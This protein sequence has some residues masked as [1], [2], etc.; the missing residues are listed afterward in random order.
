MIDTAFRFIVTH[1]GVA[2]DDRFGVGREANT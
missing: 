1:R 2:H